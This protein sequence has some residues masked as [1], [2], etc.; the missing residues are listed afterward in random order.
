MNRGMMV[1]GAGNDEYETPPWFYRGLDT[2]F[3]FDLDPAATA[4]NAKCARFYDKEHNGLERPWIARAVFVN[5]PYSNVEAW[6]HKAI[7]ASSVEPWP[8]VVMLLPVRTDNDWFRR[9]IDWSSEV[10]WLRKR[11][12]FELEGKPADSPRFASMI[13]ILRERRVL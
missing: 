4:A 8:T 12:R 9:L 3:A 11:I 10:R 13:V 1:P 7:L 6:V 5:P 2:E